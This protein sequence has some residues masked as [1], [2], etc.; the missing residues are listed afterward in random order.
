VERLRRIASESGL[1]W[2]LA[3]RILPPG[4]ETTQLRQQIDQL[5]SDIGRE[6]A[7][8]HVKPTQFEELNRNLAELRRYWADRGDLLPVTREAI[9]EG[10]H[11][12]RKVQEAVR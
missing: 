1:D 2:P 10:R 12:L 4:P 5:V 3:L 11:F 9:D 8:G 7:D 6:A